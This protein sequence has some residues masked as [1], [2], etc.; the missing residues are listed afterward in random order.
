MKKLGQIFGIIGVILLLFGIVEFLIRMS[1]STYNL[2]HILGGLVLLLTY[3]ISNAASLK[4][5]I[6]SRTTKYG[7]NAAVY[8]I[9]FL[10]ILVMVNFV[11]NRHSKRFDLTESKRFS[12]ADQTVKVLGSLEEPVELLAFFQQGE[13]GPVE[14]LLKS[15]DHASGMISY[16]FVDPVRHPEMA[17][18]HDISQ[19][20][21]IVISC[22]DRE[23]QVTEPTEEEVTNG[24]IKI[25]KRAEKKVYF[26]DGHGEHDIM[27]EEEQGYI[28]AR[29][30]VENENY[31][32]EKLL[33]GAQEKVPEDCAVLV[34]SAPQKPVLENELKMIDEFLKG[35]GKAIFMVEPR[36]SAELVSFLDGWGF[37]LGDNVIVDMVIR[38]FAGASLGIE[39]I[40]EDYGTH[41]ITRDFQQRT[42]FPMVRSVSAGDESV[43]GVNVTELASTSASSWAEKDLD[44]LFQNSEA[45]QDPGDRQGPVPVAAVAEEAGKGTKIV[46]FG[47]A[48]FANNR[49]FNYYYN[50]DLFMNVLNWLAGEEDLISIRPR[51]ARASRVQLTADQTNL[52]FYLSVLIIPEILLIFGIGVWWRRR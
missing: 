51:M 49:F 19:T 2:I 26:L 17:R 36:E 21:V 3:G 23:T 15:Y 24:I 34:V 13:G 45:K 4:T 37:E 42:I 6:G 44:L 22:G 25:S 39:P 27:S 38:L 30:A 52:I 31:A 32:S 7:T 35:G 1:F 11:L 33:L 48:E 41:E 14:D 29:K 5:G 16:A 50:G 43:E 10:A 47:D 40:V 46:V 20:D 9:I 18:E 28:E 12:L 8:I